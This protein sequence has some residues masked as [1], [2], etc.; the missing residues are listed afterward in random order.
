MTTLTALK[1]EDILLANQF[2]QE[3]PHTYA[4]DLFAVPILEDIQADVYEDFFKHRKFALCT[5]HA[6]GKDL[7]AAMFSLTLTN[8]NQNECEGTVLG[9]TFPQV[10]DIHFKELG[11]IL[12]NTNQ[13]RTIIPGKLTTSPLMYKINRKCFVVGKSP[14]QSAKGAPTPQLLSGFHSLNKFVIVTEASAVSDQVMEQIE[15]IT[16]TAGNVWIES[17]NMVINGLIDM[18]SIRREGEKIK[19]LAPE[20][21]VEY[22]ANKHYEIKNPHLLSP[23]W[24]IEKYL[25]WGESPLFRSKVI[26]EWV[27]DSNNQ[28]VSLERMDE[29]MMGRVKGVWQ[30]EDAGYARYNGIR[31]IGVGIDCAREGSDDTVVSSFEGNREFK[32]AHVFDKT[33]KQTDKGKKFVEDSRFIGKWVIDNYVI[34]HFDRIMVISIDMTGGYG[35][36][37]YDYLTNHPAVKNSKFAHVVGVKFNQLSTVSAR[38]LKDKHGKPMMLYP[39]MATQM[40]AQISHQINSDDG[41]LFF[42]DDDF[43]NEITNRGK[44][45][46]GESREKIESKNTYKQRAGK[47]PDRMDSKLLAWHGVMLKTRKAQAR[48]VDTTIE[49]K[50]GSAITS[51]AG[52]I[53]GE[54][55]Y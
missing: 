45:L 17:P 2:Y 51:M 49:K 52:T 1:D 29:L 43:K 36:G 37:I 15:G 20:I 50:G 24:V 26:G 23:G 19:D 55:D 6:F 10:R 9:P 35:V 48:Q 31:T 53:D 40:I 38:G 12:D 41:I 21:Q 46:D 33:Y 44:E 54:D 11:A 4:T 14:K 47:S 22:F 27:E 32:P 28:W 34:P 30:S 42:D 7:L 13:E 16:N 25:S 5:H 18:E 8:L 3:N 39:D